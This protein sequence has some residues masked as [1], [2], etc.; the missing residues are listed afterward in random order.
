MI[1]F[2]GFLSRL[3]LFAAAI[4]ILQI[5]VS[6]GIPEK[7][8]FE[9]FIGIQVF[10]ILATAAFHFGLMR[11]AA[12]S[13]RAFITYFMSATGLKLFLY[14]AVMVVFAVMFRDQAVGFI[15]NFFILY[16]FYT[17]FE[18]A[19]VYGKFSSLKKS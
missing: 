17:A 7:F 5:L 12:R 14:L 11:A 6:S 10:F 4:S 16:L 18:I 1:S 8:R 13:D 2:P 19:L 3:L 15:I 9:P